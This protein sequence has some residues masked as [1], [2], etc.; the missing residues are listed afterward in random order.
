M[1]VRNFVTTAILLTILIASGCKSTK[2][3]TEKPV[4]KP[5][6]TT[7]P[8]TSSS[9]KTDCM[10]FSKAANGE[11]GK[12][13]HVLY[14][15]YM[16][17][18]KLDDAF[19]LWEKAYKIAPAAD[20]QRAFHFTDGVKIYKYFLTKEGTDEATKQAYRAKIFELY[21]KRI[22]CLGKEGYVLGRKASA[23]MYYLNSTPAEI[24]QTA[25]KS[26]ELQGTDTEYIVL[27]PYANAAID[28]YKT[29]QISPAEARE[30]LNVINRIADTNSS[31]PN[32][33]YKQKYQ[34]VKAQVEDLYNYTSRSAEGVPALFDCG[35]YSDKV[36]AQYPTMP[37]DR[38]TIEKVLGRLYANGC[39]ES[40][41]LYNEWFA[42]LKQI[43]R[44]EDFSEPVTTTTTSSCPE[45]SDGTKL[46]KAGDYRG[47]IDKYKIVL[48]CPS[49]SQDKK[50][51]IALRI[52]KIYYGELGD[53]SNGRKYAR[54]SLEYRS[55]WAEPYY[56]I[57]N[58]YASSGK[59]CGSGT[60]FNSQ[61]TVWVAID[62]WKKAKS[63]EPGSK[64][65]D[66]S[67]Q[68]IN[69]YTKYM[70]N[71][72]QCFMRS[73]TEGSSYTVPCWI[74]QSTRVRYVK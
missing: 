39:D 47:A 46:L 16:K 5:P 49:I 74:N 67:Q 8:T 45:L 59:D 28:Q 41:P 48:D 18:D 22:E 23:M 70:P 72:E 57:G 37:S 62:E 15:D 26:V 55:S 50:G 43:R 25:K 11:E 71:Q 53:K 10:T 58:M 33:K 34:E 12:K 20:G 13:F 17:Q 30:V 66:K 69:E 42:K 56:V 65:A 3:T 7:K 31:D 36:K 14:R 60:G 52:G 61:R 6:E 29:G 40:N 38:E 32:N 44:D 68:R 4:P 1:S 64:F 24:Y 2:K 21:D 63:A 73:L 19:P 35:Y 51:V 54:K 27:F 9:S